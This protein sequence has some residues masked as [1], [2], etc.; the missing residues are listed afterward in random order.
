MTEIGTDLPDDSSRRDLPD[1]LRVPTVT[2]S[3][4]AHLL[5][6]SRSAAYTAAR[7]GDIPVIRIG[8]RILVPT[9]GVYRLIGHP[10]VSDEAK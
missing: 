8:H 9:V 5:G 10:L 7:R 3:R 4:A 1:P 2:V 6:I